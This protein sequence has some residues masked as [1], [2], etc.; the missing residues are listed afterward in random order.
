[1]KVWWCEEHICSGTDPNW[2][3]ASVY[4]P[5]THPNRC[6]MVEKYLLDEGTFIRAIPVPPGSDPFYVDDWVD[7]P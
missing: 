7:K 1:M 4:R 6:R 2:C 5:G 3:I